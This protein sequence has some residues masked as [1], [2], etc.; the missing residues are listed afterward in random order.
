MDLLGRVIASAASHV[1]LLLVVLPAFGAILVRLM[2]R[3]G[4]ESVYY[5]AVTNVWTGLALAVLMLI[6]FLTGAF[7]TSGDD[8]SNA[9]PDRLVSSIL[10]HG[11][12][13]PTVIPS[14]STEPARPSYIAVGPDARVIVGVSGVSVWLILLTVAVSVV[15]VQSQSPEH[16]R[17]ILRLSWIL[18]TEAALIGSLAAL[19]VV[20]LSFCSLLSVVGLSVLIAE[21]GGPLRREAARRFFI[22][23]LASGLLLTF[24]LLGLAVSHWWMQVTED[25]QH[26][27]L[28][29][30]LTTMVEQIPVLST[31]FEPALDFWNTLAPWLFLIIVAA[32]FLRVPFPPLH[33]G[34]LRVAEHADRRVVALIAVGYLPASMHLLLRVVLPVFSTQSIDL[35]DRLLVWGAIAAA[36][37]ALV[38]AATR[39]RQRR[40]AAIG[41][42]VST[43]AIGASFLQLPG[44][45]HGAALATIGT[46]AALALALLCQSEAAVRDVATSSSETPDGIF[47]AS[48][49]ALAA[50]P[51]A[52]LALVPPTAGFWG[53]LLIVEGLFPDTPAIAI[54][55]LATFACLGWTMWDEFTRVIT[56]GVSGAHPGEP[57][58]PRLAAPTL[59][60]LA[61]TLV[62][63]S[64]F[65]ASVLDHVDSQRTTESQQ[66][67]ESNAVSTIPSGATP[68][69]QERTPAL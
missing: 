47:R 21:F 45:V 65:P 61:A 58:E 51:I 4:A 10:W 64:L 27:D 54:C 53:V 43:I 33:H 7:E 25:R 13:H 31:M 22:G 19:D 40:L 50:L 34:W 59:I 9:R 1:V 11:E 5:T 52:S 23:Q 20:L 42:S 16:D 63:V 32:L 28:T 38:A 56:P 15:F 3:A 35:G 49:G 62:G 29:F 57:T 2:R 60:P 46:S 44:V 48:R 17:V 39:S 14:S 8:S 24:G 12:L 66:T 69:R 18:L 26:P 6:G 41:L 30:S 37:L 67:T 55:V 36:V 68:A